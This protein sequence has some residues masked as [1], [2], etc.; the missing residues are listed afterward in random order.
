VEQPATVAHRQAELQRQR[1]AERASGELAVSTSVACRYAGQNYEQV[2]PI[3]PAAS[4]FAAELARRFHAAHEAAYGYAMREQ[5][6]ET[7]FLAASAVAPS[8]PIS[9]LETAPPPAAAR[10]AATRSVF[11]GSSGWVDATIVRRGELG[12]GDEVEGPAVIEEPDSTTYVAAGFGASLHE[13]RCLV[14][15]ARG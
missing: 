3:D 8:P 1:H 13:S 6:I 12:V 4:D 11:A 2:V 10:G 14:V 7:V 15:E 9:L 5:P